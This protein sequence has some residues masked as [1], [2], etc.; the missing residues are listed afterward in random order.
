MRKTFFIAL[1]A[2]FICNAQAQVKFDALQITPQ[3]PKINQTVSFKFNATLSPLID[4]KK[5]DVVIYLCNKN[6][7]KALEPKMLQS[8]KLYS[9]SFK[10]DSNTSCIAF[11]FSA[12]D[13]KVKDNNASKGYIVPVYTK[14]NNPVIDYYLWAGRLYSGYGE[15]LFGMATDAA[16][17]LSLLEEGVKLNPGA[18]EDNGYFF[19]YLNAVN[20]VKKKE[21]E[22]IILQELKTIAAKPVLKET[23]YNI[24]TQWYTRLKMKP[25]ADS[26]TALMKEKYPDGNWKKQTY[27]T[28]INKAKDA[29]GK[30]TAFEE[31]IKAYPPKE[32]DKP[33][34]N[35]Y[36][37]VIAS[38]YHKEKNYDSFKVWTNDLP[39]SEKAN[40]YNNLSWNM[41]L[42][43]ENLPEARLIS[44]EATD[45]AKKEM[46]TP[47]EKKPDGFTK[48][49]WDE[50]RKGMYAMFADTYAFILYNL[51][52]YK[53]GFEYAKEA[54]AIN[55]FKNSEYNER[56]GQLL[57][58]AM[59]D[60]TVKKE[61][62]QFV[63][64]GVASSK[65]KAILKTLYVK[66]KKTE[67]GYDEYLTGLEMTSTIKKREELA[68][69]M[70]NEAAP[71]FSLKDLDDKDISLES[72]K[73]KVVV[74][75]FWATWCGP[76]IASMPAMKTALEKLKARDDVAFVFVDTWQTEADKK[77]NA[78]DFMKK[79]NYPFHVLLDNDDK[80][81]ADFKVSGIPTKF[82]IDKA[83]NIRFKSVGFGG[84]D[85]ALVDEIST[86][87][88]LASKN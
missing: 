2:A 73:G 60:A 1:L 86:M 61:I 31:F 46:N 17:N 45:W 83:G 7:T 68:K 36:K 64:D 52:D 37:G 88:E 28:A 66:E 70:I 41:A 21:G 79:N 55:E 40:T 43:K 59:P 8:G 65:T 33:M 24:L 69:T 34:I 78:A 13:N 54:A 15:S 39:M 6:G 35:F 80:V 30:K 85:D 50:N 4:E 20:A 53:T 23:D 82:V 67:V 84:N 58:K 71:K 49:Q 77:Q 87:V 22:P 47:K 48:K 18:K 14:D 72:L 29:S 12:N 44:F 56:Y 63:K 11:G 74:V 9:G 42:A 38:A 10:L 19:S 51:E 16:K 81:V 57:E 27:S 3:F 75:D 32:E 26:F 62:E 25:L 76:C 5:V